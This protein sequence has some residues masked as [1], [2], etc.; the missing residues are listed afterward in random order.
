MHFRTQIKNVT[1]V[2]EGRR[3]FGTL[4]IDD[5]RIDDFIVG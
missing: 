1:M 2:N 4:V 5:N 3:L